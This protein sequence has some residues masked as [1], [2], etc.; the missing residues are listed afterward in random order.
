MTGKKWAAIG[1]SASIVVVVIL[2][3]IFTGGSDDSKDA[4]PVAAPADP[5]ASSTVRTPKAH[6]GSDLIGRPVTIVEA[7]GGQPV[8]QTGGPAPFP[9][10]AEAV[11]APTG[12]TLQQVPS[13]VTLM[14]SDSDGPT[15]VDGDVMTGYAQSPVGAALVTA[16]YIGLGVALGPVYA[17]FFEHYA[18]QLVA[19]DPAFLDEV[20]ARGAAQGSSTPKPADG[21]LAP[22]WFRIS[23]CTPD[24][25]TVEAAMPSVADAVGDVDTIDASAT[26]H[27]AVRV[28]LAWQD[29]EWQIVSGRSLPAVEELD[30]SWVLWN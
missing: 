28:S 21:F 5:P 6:V 18:R 7:P 26:A 1:R 29:G 11:A 23:H 27:P 24:F 19:E 17:D 13:G 2:A 20:R 25:C 30:G 12:L 8:E 4:S 22:R 3:L 10:G 16:N 15:A 14:V 9:V